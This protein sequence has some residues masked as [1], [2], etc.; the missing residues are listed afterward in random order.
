MKRLLALLIVLLCACPAN[1]NIQQMHRIVAKNK[2]SVLTSPASFQQG[3]LP[4][5]TY[6]GCEDVYMFGGD[7]TANKDG[8]DRLITRDSGGGTAFDR[9]FVLRFD[10][11]DIPS[12][13]TI[14][15]ATL[16]LYNAGTVQGGTTYLYASLRDWSE[17]QATWNVYTTGNNWSTAG[18]RGSSTDMTGTFGTS[19]GDFANAAISASASEVTF[20]STADFVTLVQNALDGDGIVDMV[21][22]DTA[23][24]GVYN[25][26]TASE[27]ATASQRPKLTVTWS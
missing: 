16:T 1:A 2:V 10:I 20:A 26:W 21:A 15:S 27:G 9:T 3:N 13:S 23:D 6:A 24:A 11:S 14:T 22:H 7:A 19:T 17:T 8:D 4:D 18:C 25:E 5:A 12:G